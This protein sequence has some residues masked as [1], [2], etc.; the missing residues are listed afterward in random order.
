MLGL[1]EVLY[2]MESSLCVH[3]HY[4]V[5]DSAGVVTVFAPVIVVEMH[6]VIFVD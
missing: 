6:L 3:L 2:S 4:F 5:H 1:C